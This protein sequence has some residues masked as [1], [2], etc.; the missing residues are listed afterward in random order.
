MQT[1]YWISLLSICVLQQL[2]TF[3]MSR[4]RFVPGQSNEIKQE[5]NNRTSLLLGVFWHLW[6]VLCL[7][8]R[9]NSES[10]IVINSWTS[11]LSDFV[12]SRFLLW[13]FRSN[14]VPHKIT[15]R[16]EER[17]VKKKEFIKIYISKQQNYNN[18][19]EVS[20]NFRRTTVDP[21]R[22]LMDAWA[23]GRTVGKDQNVSTFPLYLAALTSFKGIF[24]EKQQTWSILTDRQIPR[25]SVVQVT[26]TRIAP[27]SLTNSG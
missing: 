25:C 19:A 16:N 21:G 27:D 11:F 1:I 9:R 10:E 14:F 22:R 18:Y 12:S 13:P 26:C 15:L 23:P 2:F 4:T 24:V 8:N 20:I 5:K 17:K 6:E 3:V 7:L